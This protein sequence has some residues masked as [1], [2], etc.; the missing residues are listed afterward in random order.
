MIMATSDYDSMMGRTGGSPAGDSA[1]T[2]GGKTSKGGKAWLLVLAFLAVGGA[3]AY[4]V[5]TTE[6]QKDDSSELKRT[7]ASNRDAVND[8]ISLIMKRAEDADAEFE[9]FKADSAKNSG[10][11][12]DHLNTIQDKSNSEL[13]KIKNELSLQSQRTDE[14]LSV[15]VEQKQ[16]L[17]AATQQITDL[18]IEL[19]DK[20]T[21][22]DLQAV[23]STL[24][25]RITKESKRISNIEYARRKEKVAIEDRIKQIDSELL[26]RAAKAAEE[27][28]KP[29]GP[30]NE[31]KP[32]IPANQGN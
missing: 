26:A 2:K 4:L 15:V 5:M 30:A 28:K 13:A 25:A 20:A 18:K 1:S 9:K 32:G 11:I 27:E 6:K 22:T 12:I 17:D 8:R 24:E 19:G 14:L 10:I 7:F 23:S 16:Q 21:K 3:L 31:W 29:D